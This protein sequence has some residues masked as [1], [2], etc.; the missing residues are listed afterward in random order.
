MKLVWINPVTKHYQFLWSLCL[1]SD[2]V[3]NQQNWE[4]DNSRNRIGYIIARARWEPH[5]WVVNFKK[6]IGLVLDPE[7][8]WTSAAKDWC[9]AIVDGIFLLGHKIMM[10]CW[11]QVCWKIPVLDKNERGAWMLQPLEKH[12][13]WGKWVL[14]LLYIKFSKYWNDGFLAAAYLGQTATSSS[15]QRQTP[16][17]CCPQLRHEGNTI[18]PAKVT[19]KA[20]KVNRIC[21]FV[22][23]LE[24]SGCLRWRTFWPFVGSGS[25]IPRT[26]REP[27]VFASRPFT[28][29]AVRQDLGKF[30]HFLSRFAFHFCFGFV[31]PVILFPFDEAGRNEMPHGDTGMLP[32]GEEGSLSGGSCLSESADSFVL[33]QDPI[34]FACE[35]VR[36]LCITTLTVSVVQLF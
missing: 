26:Q 2:W 33:W 22:W 35:K 15:L 27:T 13:R 25:V 21:L 19:A 17:L 36:D 10:P 18:R 3:L 1:R 24:R 7:V 34:G 11:L 12:S 6:Y 4:D 30:P 8:R 28:F 9:F 31:H 20:A 32:H 16:H 5:L 23:I 29:D 14:Q